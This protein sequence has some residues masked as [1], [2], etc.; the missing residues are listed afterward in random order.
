M[1]ATGYE[2]PVDASEDGY[3]DH[4]RTPNRSVD[5]GKPFQF[6]PRSRLITSFTIKRRRIDAQTNDSRSCREV[7]LSYETHLPLVATVNETLRSRD[8]DQDFVSPGIPFLGVHQAE[9][10][11]RQAGQGNRRQD[12]E[13]MIAFGLAGPESPKLGGRALPTGCRCFERGGG[14]RQRTPWRS[15]V[16]TRRSS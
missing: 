7:P 1:K 4:V 10:H 11:R 3:F 12:W 8:G 2:I 15:P 5:M 9:N 6:A 13:S 14:A 16:T